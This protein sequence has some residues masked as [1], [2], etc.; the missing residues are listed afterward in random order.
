MQEYDAGNDNDNDSWVGCEDMSHWLMDK[1]FQTPTWVDPANSRDSNVWAKE[2][3]QVPVSY[4]WQ[5]Y[6]FISR[7]YEPTLQVL[8]CCLGILYQ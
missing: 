5:K 6:L 7:V 1:N 4:H 2:F 3:I 8:K